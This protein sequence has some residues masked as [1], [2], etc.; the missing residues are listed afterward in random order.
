VPSDIRLQ[1]KSLVKVLMVGFVGGWVAGALGLGGGA[2][3][4]P[5]LLTMGIPPKV[6]AATGLYLVTFS[7]ISSTFVYWL[8]GEL[9]VPYSLWIS[10]AAIVGTILGVL[11][12]EWYMRI[13]G[14]Q[15]VIVWVLV[16]IFFLSVVAIPIFGGK[17][18]KEQY[19]AGYDIF[20]FHSLCK[21]T[22]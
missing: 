14:R 18:L 16:F 10:I 22:K 2:I 15:S 7:K 1:G 3:F 4:N 8:F 13:S 6:S 5:V 20:A 12:S 21:A 11:I 9:N 19:D 17:N